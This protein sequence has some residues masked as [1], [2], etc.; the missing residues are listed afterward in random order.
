MGSESTVKLPCSHRY[1]AG[2]GGI[3]PESLP[4]Y[5]ANV[6]V[7]D[8]QE[9]QAKVSVMVAVCLSG[10]VADSGRGWALLGDAHSGEFRA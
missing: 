10:A 6:P 7:S 4:L 9:L 8:N 5:H 3:F 1:L 2:I